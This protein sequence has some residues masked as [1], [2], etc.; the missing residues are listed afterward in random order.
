MWFEALFGLF[1]E[2]IGIFGRAGIA[3]GTKLDLFFLGRDVGK[4]G[5]LLAKVHRCAGHEKPDSPSAIECEHGEC[6][7]GDPDTEVRL[8]RA[9]LDALGHFRDDRER[10]VVVALQENGEEADAEEYQ[11]KRMVVP[12]RT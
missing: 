2:P 1:E 5:E 6:I 9:V 3:G 8:T 4:S 11:C 12:F 10:P 7:R